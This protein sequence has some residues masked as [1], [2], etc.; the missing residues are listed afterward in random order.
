MNPIDSTTVIIWKL[1]DPKPVTGWRSTGLDNPARHVIW[2][3]S[4]WGRKIIKD[5]WATR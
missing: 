1:G 4:Y 5:A 3:W 2:S